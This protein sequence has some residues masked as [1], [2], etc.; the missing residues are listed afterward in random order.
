MVEFGEEER[1]RG[2]EGKG[3]RR[4]RENCGGNGILSHMRDHV[5]MIY[6]ALVSLIVGC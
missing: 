5:I 6:D 4:V 2:G 3:D 1:R